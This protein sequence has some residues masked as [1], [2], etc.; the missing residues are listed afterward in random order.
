MT[1]NLLEIVH[2]P[3]RLTTQAEFKE[4]FI[5]K[6]ESSFK[7]KDQTRPMA[8]MLASSGEILMAFPNLENQAKKSKSMSE[9]K[10]L[11]K[12]ARCVAYGF[13]TEAW[14]KKMHMNDRENLQLLHGLD[15]QVSML[16]D[17]Q[18]VLL[19]YIE[20]REIGNKINRMQAVW[21]VKGTKLGPVSIMA[22]PTELSGTMV[23]ILE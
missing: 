21:D 23:N 19:A 3:Y 10:V 16:S 1:M 14:I 5:K 4:W 22:S 15:Y 8:C 7:G 2:V 9:M 11:A 13:V 12:V 18:E 20:I 6:T 17:R